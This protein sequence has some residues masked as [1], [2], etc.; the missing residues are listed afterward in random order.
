MTDI[1]MAVERDVARRAF[2]D[3][4]AHGIEVG[5]MV[6]RLAPGLL[7]AHVAGGTPDRPARVPRVAR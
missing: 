4:H 7:R 6:E 3:H 2:V 5:A 1:A